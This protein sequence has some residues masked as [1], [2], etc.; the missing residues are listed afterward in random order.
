[1]GRA[2]KAEDVTEL[3]KPSASRIR[4]SGGRPRVGQ[5]QRAELRLLLVSRRGGV[6][7][8]KESEG[9]KAKMKGKKKSQ[10]S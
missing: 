6:K 7:M 1:M 4:L 5:R 10:I 2:D 3:L 9:E 8:R